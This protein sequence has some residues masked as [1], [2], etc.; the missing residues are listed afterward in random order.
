MARRHDEDLGL[1][2]AITALERSLEVLRA[3]RDRINAV[4]GRVIK[5]GALRSYILAV[6][7]GTILPLGPT[8]I[9]R[10]LHAEGYRVDSRTIAS[11]LIALKREGLVI[12][13]GRSQWRRV[14]LH[15]AEV[16]S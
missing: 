11:T 1:D 16:D 5:Y 4:R 12:S 6:M 7:G 15:R 10:A 8:T 14:D 9:A 2:D 3:Q 13:L